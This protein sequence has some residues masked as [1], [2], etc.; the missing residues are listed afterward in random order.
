MEGTAW[1][2][3]R[4]QAGS[5]VFAEQ[6]EACRAWGLSGC[7]EVWKEKVN[8]RPMGRTEVPSQEI[9]MHAVGSSSQAWGQKSSLLRPELWLEVTLR[10]DYSETCLSLFHLSFLFRKKN[11]KLWKRGTSMWPSHFGVKLKAN[12]V[13]CVARR[14]QPAPTLEKRQSEPPIQPLKLWQVK[15]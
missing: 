7:K 5:C 8:G 4:G 1:Q 6:R 10:L 2:R 9:W 11:K 12:E 15:S 14:A 13:Y 3:P